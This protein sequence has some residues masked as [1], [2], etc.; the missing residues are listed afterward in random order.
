MTKEQLS[1]RDLD[2]LLYLFITGLQPGDSFSVN[3]NKITIASIAKDKSMRWDVNG[4]KKKLY[5]TNGHYY[6]YNGKARKPDWY[7]Q[8]IR[9]IEGILIVDLLNVRNPFHEL[10]EIA[11]L[12]KDA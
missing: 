10:S 12:I 11:K 7:H 1:G 2:E 4:T 3:K 8:S 6:G 9:D 5:Y